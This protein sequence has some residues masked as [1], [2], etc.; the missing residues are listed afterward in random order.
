MLSLIFPF[1]ALFLMFGWIETKVGHKIGL[2]LLSIGFI[3]LIGCLII[4]ALAMRTI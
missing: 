4:I 1:T 3:G 2:L